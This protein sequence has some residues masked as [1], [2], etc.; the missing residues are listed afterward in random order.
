MPNYEVALEV[1]FQTM[2]SILRQNLEYITPKCEVNNAKCGVN[3]AKICFIVLTPGDRTCSFITEFS[4]L[5]Q[6]YLAIKLA[7]I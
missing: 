3:N 7:I 6:V 1:L 2:E 4:R 5:N